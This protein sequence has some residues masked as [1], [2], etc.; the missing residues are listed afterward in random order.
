MRLR[1][2]LRCALWECSVPH[3]V[4]I[5]NLSRHFGDCTALDCVSLAIEPGEMVAL[6]G[7]SGS[8]APE[9]FRRHGE[10]YITE[11]RAYRHGR[12]FF[13]DQM[14]NNF[15]HIGLIRLMLPNAKIIDV[16]RD[17]IP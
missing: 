14:P 12:P 10:R 15:R 7:A 17:P 4:T 11:T 1:Q 2:T 16:R 8:L 6:I 5:S 3:A 9:K 13:I